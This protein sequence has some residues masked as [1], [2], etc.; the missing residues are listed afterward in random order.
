MTVGDYTAQERLG[1]RKIQFPYKPTSKM[2]WQRNFEQCSINNGFGLIMV[3][4]RYMQH[5]DG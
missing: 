1:I 4:A 3:L 5:I 2:E